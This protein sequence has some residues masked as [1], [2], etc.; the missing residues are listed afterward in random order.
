MTVT[1]VTA[2]TSEPITRAEAKAH[3]R[4][5]STAEDTLIDNLIKA[6]RFS[7]D[8][9]DGWLNRALI[10]Q[11][12]KLYLDRFPLSSRTPVIVPLPPLQSVTHI[13]YYD[14]D[15]TQQTWGASNYVVDSA[16]EPGLIF[17]AYNVVWPTTRDMPNAVEIQFVAGY[18]ASSTYIPEAIRQAG[19]LQ[20]GHWYA[21]R[22]SVAVGASV[23]TMPQASEWLLRPYHVRMPDHCEE[24]Y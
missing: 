15:G 13:K 8:G 24:R 14:A 2:P 20:I 9:K 18:G 16:A 5:D 3:L 12:W 21:N 10:T 1:L 19:L 7:V 6:F 23:Q 4:V 17:P 11:T 22:E